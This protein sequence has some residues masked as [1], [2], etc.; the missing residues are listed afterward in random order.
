MGDYRNDRKILTVLLILTLPAV[1]LCDGNLPTLQLPPSSPS[2]P[3]GTEFCN[4]VTGMNLETRDSVIAEQIL[5]GNIPEFL[6]EFTQV[7]FTVKIN[8]KPH[9]VQ[10][11]VL[12]DYLAIGS[13]R[14]FVYMPMKP[15]TAQRIADSLDCVL[16]TRK[17]VDIIYRH[18]TIR[19]RPQPIPPG[20]AMTTVPDFVQHTDSIQMQMSQSGISRTGE[21][22]IDG[23][24]KSLII[25]N[26]IYDDLPQGA[27]HPVVIYG[28]HRM[29]GSPIQPVYNGHRNTWVDYSHGVRLVQ[30]TV[31]VN[32]QERTVGEILSDNHLHPLLSDE[33]VIERPY[34]PFQGP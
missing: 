1:L 31:I 2:A 12:R 4:Q 14:D 17:I 21:F 20:P 10:L 7:E 13:E 18:A 8:R 27:E 24:K 5:S 28:W 16:P 30:E 26:S 33:G 34:Y 6:R 22:L 9:R 3:V 29:N 32:G 15:S 11:F 25:S 23:H 19:L